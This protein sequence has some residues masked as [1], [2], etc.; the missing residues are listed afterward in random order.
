MNIFKELLLNKLESPSRLKFIKIIFGS[1]DSVEDSDLVS[2]SLSKKLKTFFRS[3]GYE[4]DVPN[5]FFFEIQD[6]Y[7]AVTGTW[8]DDGDKDFQVMTD[9]HGNIFDQRVGT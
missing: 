1:N 9:L 5:D 2:M 6:D 7:M 3:K 8:G 4:I